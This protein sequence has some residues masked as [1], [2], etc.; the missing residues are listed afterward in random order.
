M[1][2]KTTFGVA[3]GQKDGVWSVWLARF[4]EGRRERVTV[5]TPQ[6]AHALAAE[7]Q[8]A[9]HRAEHAEAQGPHFKMVVAG[10]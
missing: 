5:M 8:S 4:V 6:E 9:A 7:L 1:K 10:G 3:N 2:R